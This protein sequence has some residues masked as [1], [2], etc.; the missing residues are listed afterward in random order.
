MSIRHVVTDYTLAFPSSCKRELVFY[1]GK[2]IDTKPA[3]INDLKGLDERSRLLI[4]SF[5]AAKE[6]L[7]PQNTL[8]GT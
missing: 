4:K 5:E 1:D 6:P 8:R 2:W 7:F 3:H